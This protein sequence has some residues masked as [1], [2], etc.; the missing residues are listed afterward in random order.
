MAPPW[1][2]RFPMAFVVDSVLILLMLGMTSW[3]SPVEGYGFMGLKGDYCSRLVVAGA[4][5][6]PQRQDECAV[7]VYTAQ[8]HTK[9][10]CDDF[11]DRR[12][13]DNIPDCCPDFYTH[14]RGH[15]P[16][17]DPPPNVTQ[18]LPQ[19]QGCWD[20]DY[21]HDVGDHIRRNC[22]VCVCRPLAS[23]H[24]E[25]LEFQCEDSVCLIQEDL[26]HKVNSYPEYYRWTAANYSFLWGLTLDEGYRFRLGTFRPEED[27][28]RMTEMRTDPRTP[29]PDSFDARQ[30]WPGL[31][32]DIRDQGNCA[33]SWAFSTTALAADRIAIMTKGARNL[34]LSVQQLISCNSNG[35]KG[36]SGGFVDRAWWYLRKRG[37]VAEECFPFE[38]ASDTSRRCPVQTVMD[39]AGVLECPDPASNERRL[40]ETT[41]PYRIAPRESEI[42]YEIMTNGPVQAV[43]HVYPDLFMY[44]SGVYRTSSDLREDVRFVNYLNPLAYHSVR[45]IGWG[46]DHAHDQP[47]KYWICANSW[48]TGW[49]EEGTFRIVRGENE[50]QIESFVVGVWGRR[51]GAAFDNDEEL[52]R[53]RRTLAHFRQRRQQLRANTDEAL[54]SLRQLLP[55]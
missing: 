22:R 13:A 12:D 47:L 46:I 9:C 35:Q 21:F 23:D 16:A 32:H 17:P 14:C 39:L 4:G 6:C 26:I 48:G 31:I 2:Y 19:V 53:R 15:H 44:R 38:G 51:L 3:S 28:S 10:Y 50:A 36:C 34:S 43:F 29:V 1:K 40:Y 55:T 8:G 49:G 5:C 30:H 11:C 7:D 52:R 33:A 41:P 42:Q 45:I 27:V 54:Q 25:V 37:V 20:G 18:A 24:G